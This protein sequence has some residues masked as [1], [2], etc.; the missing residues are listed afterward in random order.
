M[1]SIYILAVLVLVAIVVFGFAINKQVT[2][3]VVADNSLQTEN[4]Q[5]TT[6]AVADN[7]LKVFQGRITNAKPPVGSLEGV[8]VTDKGCY[9][10]GV[11]LV[12]C[13][14]DIETS[15]GSLNFIYRHNMDIQP[16]LSMFGEEKVIVDVLDADGNARVIRT[17]DVGGMM[18]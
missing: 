13:N 7:S 14:T 10:V 6:N 2:G 9:G 15:K 11:N 17:I 12:E 5:V 1:K 4:K 16:C 3:N 18:H 8:A